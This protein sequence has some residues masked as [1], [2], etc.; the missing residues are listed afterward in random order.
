MD[1]NYV[2]GGISSVISGRNKT[3]KQDKALAALFS[4]KGTAVKQKL[5]QVYVLGICRDSG[6]F[7]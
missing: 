6:F 7:T 4:P 5:I 1:D 2:F 3:P